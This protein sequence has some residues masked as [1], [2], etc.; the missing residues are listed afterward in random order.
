MESLLDKKYYGDIRKEIAELE[1]PGCTERIN[2]LE[3]ENKKLKEELRKYTEVQSFEQMQDYVAKKTKK[4]RARKVIVCY[5]KDCG[6]YFSTK[7]KLAKY[8]ADCKK[9]R[10]NEYK[11][12]WLE[13]QKSLK[14]A[15]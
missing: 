15:K 1:C 2:E 12:Q 11:K 14:S 3:S 10:I 4:R 9:K 5:C 6:K 13:K 8:C 7:S